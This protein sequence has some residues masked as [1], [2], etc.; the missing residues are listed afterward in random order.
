MNIESKLQWGGF[1][2]SFD[3]A[4]YF[5][6]GGYAISDQRLGTKAIILKDDQILRE[7]NR[8]YYHADVYE[9]PIAITGQKGV[10][11]STAL[12]SAA[13]KQVGGDVNSVTGV[14][15]FDNAAAL[16]KAGGDITKT[17]RAKALSKLGYT[18]HSYDATSG[19]MVSKKPDTEPPKQ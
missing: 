6:N 5:R 3:G 2:F 16:E 10:S 18:D 13:I 17:P 11:T 19:K 1:G 9:Y 7:I 15:G 12:Y 8:S 14:A 4:I